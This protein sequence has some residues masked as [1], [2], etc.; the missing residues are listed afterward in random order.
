MYLF[1]AAAAP[2]LVVCCPTAMINYYRAMVGSSFLNRTWPVLEVPTLMI[3]GE[4]R[5][6][7]RQRTDH[8]HRRLCARLPPALYSQLQPLGAAR[9]TRPGQHLHARIPRPRKA[10]SRPR[11]GM[12]SPDEIRHKLMDL[13]QQ[14]GSQQNHLPVRSRSPTGG[15]NLAGPDALCAGCGALN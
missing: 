15:R 10:G 7:P 8:R 4:E 13:V 11:F 6:G 9:T 5:H 3:W 2:N 14:R 12:T 1:K